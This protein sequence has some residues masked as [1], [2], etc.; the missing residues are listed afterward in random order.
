MNKLKKNATT[1]KQ[2]LFVS[3]AA[4]LFLTSLT[5]YIL[6]IE[7]YDG[8][9]DASMDY[10]VFMV[11][12]LVFLIYT[13]YAIIKSDKDLTMARILTLG[14]CGAIGGLYS[15]GV[16]FRSLAKVLSKG[17]EFVFTDYQIYLYAGIVGL[18]LTVIAF[19]QYLEAKKD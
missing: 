15:L 1:I 6:S 18:I 5:V 19:F 4:V 7:A 11:L 8:G 16:F 17:N 14:L 13:V 9:F 10:L 12:S 3:L 2:I